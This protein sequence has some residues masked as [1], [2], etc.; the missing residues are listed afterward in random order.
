MRSDAQEYEVPREPMLQSVLDQQGTYLVLLKGIGDVARGQRVPEEVTSELPGDV[1]PDE[2]VR[3]LHEV[4]GLRQ[5]YDELYLSAASWGAQP[6]QRVD[7]KEP[8][9]LVEEKGLGYAEGRV[10]HIMFLLQNADAE[11]ARMYFEEINE[12]L[13]TLKKRKRP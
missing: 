5:V 7:R 8:L 9:L 6:V 4:S 10:V 2:A 13:V 1:L 11:Q 3:A 12:L